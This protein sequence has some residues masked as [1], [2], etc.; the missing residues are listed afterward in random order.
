MQVP[1]ELSFRDVE[2]TAELEDLIRQKVDKLE[3]I[4]D[5]ITSCRVH[6]ERVQE[7]QRSGNPVGMRIEV[8]VPRHNEIIVTQEIDSD[9]AG[10]PLPRLI[11]DTFAA[12]R[13]KLQE[14]TERQRGQVKPGATVDQVAVVAKLFPDR[15]YG[16][17]ET[18]DRREVFFHRNSVLDSD[19]DRLE[20]GTGVRF[21]E[22]EGEK[23]PQ[24]SSVLII[25]KPGV[26]SPKAAEEGR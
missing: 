3:Q 13:R 9:Q 4:C 2:K 22:E 26:S 20:V 21:V 1:L 8:R 19:F 12:A 10:E 16:F 7:S 11:R 17:L 6:V 15:D 23:G 25:D 18:M 14:L 24:A 5:T